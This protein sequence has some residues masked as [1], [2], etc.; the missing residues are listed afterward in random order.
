[1][2]Q[3]GAALVK[4]LREKTGAG[5]MDCKRAL[6]ETHGDLEAAAEWLRAKG[7]SRAIG[8]ADR[9]ARE[10][11]VA[12][13]I[14]GGKGA[15]VE[16]NAETD[17]VARNELFRG[18]A[19]A[20]AKAALGV[21]GEREKLLEAPLPDGGTRVRDR[22]AQLIATIGENIVVRR[23]AAVGVSDG[24]IASY[25]HIA[26]GQGL[27]NVGVL[28][29]IESTGRSDVLHDIGRRIALHVAAASPLWVSEDDIQPD[30]AAEKR[31]ALAAD[32][33][34]SGKPPDVVAKMLEGRWRKFHSETV[35]LRQAFVLNP[36]QTVAA[37]LAEAE[38]AA[39]AAI[40]V[41]AFVRF[42]TGESLDAA[43]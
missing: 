15:I 9:V 1:M 39:G 3:I 38:Q 27:G 31:A 29:A 30:V 18:T 13:C 4:E 26:A 24:V 42:K 19:V 11:L 25:I 28:V 7:I 2:T 43:H 12:L 35:L 17:F 8:K 37:A 6:G 40:A 41:A 14:E 20:L 34:K 21:G 22:I 23:S 32:A 33:A 16:L 10:G 5:L 36:E